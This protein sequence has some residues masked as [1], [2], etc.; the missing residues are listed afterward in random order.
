M[1][2]EGGW[3]YRCRAQEI[4]LD[5]KFKFGDH[6]HG[7]AEARGPREKVALEERE[8]GSGGNQHGGPLSCSP[9]ANGGSE[10]SHEPAWGG[11]EGGGQDPRRVF[12]PS[13]ARSAR[14]SSD[15]GTRRGQCQSGVGVMESGRTPGC[16]ETGVSQRRS[17]V[18]APVPHSTLWGLGQGGCHRDLS[19]LVHG[20]VSLTQVSFLQGC[21][22]YLDSDVASYCRTKE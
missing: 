9:R 5:R 15:L 13:S 3:I 6:R 11:S 1:T 10:D 12:C 19:A 17:L 20:S 22:L 8:A 14:H 2:P 7:W 18:V 21:S 16:P 4:G